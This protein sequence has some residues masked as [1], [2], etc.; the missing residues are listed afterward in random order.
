MSILQWVNNNKHEHSGSHLVLLDIQHGVGMG[1]YQP[2][3][4]SISLWQL[5]CCHGDQ[6][7]ALVKPV[8]Q[9]FKFLVL[10]KFCRAFPDGY[11]L[12]YPFSQGVEVNVLR[13]QFSKLLENHQIKGSY[14]QKKCVNLLSWN[15]ENHSLPS[16]S[17]RPSLVEKPTVHFY[18]WKMNITNLRTW[19]RG[20]NHQ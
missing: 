13:C 4:V 7:V 2:R 18:C 11:P 15:Q 9:T 12:W 16:L 1:G 14:Y 8:Q 6:A 5:T 19:K 3:S 17:Y 20:G 10:V